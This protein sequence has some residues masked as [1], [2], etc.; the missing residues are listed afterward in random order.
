MSKPFKTFGDI[1][2]YAIDRE[3]DAQLFYRALSK[4]A[5]YP[6]LTQLFEQLA[7][8][9]RAHQKKLAQVK[10]GHFKMLYGDMPAFGLGI[11]EIAPQVEPYADM[12]IGEALILAMNKEKQAYQ[13]YLGLAQEAETDELAEV[14]MTLAHEE[15]NH[16]VR[17]EIIF[18]DRISHQAE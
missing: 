4:R 12:S 9:E 18:D 6:E 3:I 8:Q 17:L 1:L 7:D 10:Q 15:A 14:F 2:D 16:K 11:A 13:L 5:S